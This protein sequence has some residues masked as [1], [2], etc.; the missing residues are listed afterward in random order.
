MAM[1]L[2]LALIAS[3]IVLLVVASI[4]PA[5]AQG[6]FEVRTDKLSY[7]A[8]ES[9]NITGKVG[10]V[11]G[12]GEQVQIQVYNSRNT[13]HVSASVPVAAGD[14]SFK[15]SF[16]IKGGS[17]PSGPYG[18]VASYGGALAQTQF[19]VAAAAAATG[20]QQQEGPGSGAVKE[21]AIKTDRQSYPAGAPVVVTGRAG[22]MPVSIKVFDPAG[23]EMAPTAQAQLLPDGTFQYMLSAGRLAGDYRVVASR[24]DLS[25]EVRFT[26]TGD[27]PPSLGG[28]RVVAVGKVSSPLTTVRVSNAPADVY[29][30]YVELPSYEEVKKV[31]SPRGWMGEVDGTA[32]TFLTEDRPIEQGR[33]MTFRI[34]ASPTVRLL[35]WTAYD[36]DG[37]VIDVGVANV[38]VRGMTS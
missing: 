21:L 11:K 14:G 37:N 24:G 35:D 34:Y 26:V 23:K 19:I 12:G 7:A 3:A 29:E 15:Y 18:V 31:R 10:Q 9:V 38:R 4:L 28:T 36:A 1:Q 33:S 27:G 20:G 5:L 32:V 25:A 16:A 8:G 2:Q 22:G 30:L 13:V 17:A 6:A